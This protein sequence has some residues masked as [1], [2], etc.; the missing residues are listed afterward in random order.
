MD[1]K[2]VL[3]IGTGEGLMHSEMIQLF[4]LLTQNDGLLSNNINLLAD[5]R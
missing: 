3:W 5:R 1:R 4:Q 2:G